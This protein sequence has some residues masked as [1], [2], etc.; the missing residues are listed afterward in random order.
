MPALPVVLTLLVALVMPVQQ[1][2]KRPAPVG[3]GRIAGTVVDQ[4]SGRPIRFAAVLLQSSEDV[5]QE[6]TDGSGTFSFDRLPAGAYR[7][8]FSKPGYLETA[9]GQARPG[10]DTP[11]KQIVLRD[12]EPVTRLVVPL[13]HGGVIAGTIRD[14]RG[15]PVYGAVVSVS[16][17]VTWHG[18]RQLEEV[19]GATADERG[20]YDSAQAEKEHEQAPP[21]EE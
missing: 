3:T 16:R 1:R 2:D 6:A 9:Y 10:T 14:D 19:E 13:S 7:L 11:G 8:R 18:V 21:V 15:D 4:E 20:N 12:R 17:W 5:R